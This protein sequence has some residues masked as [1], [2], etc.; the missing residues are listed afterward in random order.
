MRSNLIN[1]QR[2]YIDL[3]FHLSRF[4][5]CQTAKPLKRGDRGKIGATGEFKWWKNSKPWENQRKGGWP[6][7]HQSFMRMKLGKLLK[8]Q[9]VQDAIAERRK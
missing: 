8:L 1:R 7:S 2:R 9:H 3:R 6:H 5:I 4:L